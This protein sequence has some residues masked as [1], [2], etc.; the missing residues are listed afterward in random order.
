M[1]D[2]A[3][4]YLGWGSEGC[5]CFLLTWQQCV[6]LQDFTCG[7]RH[8]EARSRCSRCS[9]SLPTVDQHPVVLPRALPMLTPA[10]APPAAAACWA[11]RQRRCQR[12]PP[13]AAGRRAAAIS[14]VAVGFLP[15]RGCSVGGFYDTH[16]AG[17]P[18]HDCQ[19]MWQPAAA[20][21]ARLAATQR[22]RT[23]STAA[24][25][26]SP[27][28]SASGSGQPAEAARVPA[29]AKALERDILSSDNQRRTKELVDA[30]WQSLE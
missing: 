4:H 29:A 18:G 26:D 21:E 7:H 6:S 28:V 20:A 16:V 24:T 9:P 17:E 25:T 2:C 19:A 30:A 13:P 12:A 3:T 23:D 8:R 1:L 11:R 14:V 27:S 10:A 22:S 5:L 15:W